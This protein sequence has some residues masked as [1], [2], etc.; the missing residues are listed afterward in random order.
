MHRVSATE[1]IDTLGIAHF[2]GQSTFGALP[3]EVIVDMLENGEIW[4]LA[5]GE[6]IIREDEAARDFQVI[7]QGKIAYY[8]HCEGH[9]VLTRHFAPGEQAG[10]D[11][12]LG[13]IRHN[14][15]DVAVQDTM[16]LSITSVQ[17]H[18]LHRR[19]PSAFG[20]LMINLARELSR[21]I[22]MLEDVITTSTGWMPAE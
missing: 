20:V 22:E 17:F 1:V 13:L 21:E 5:K 15:T 7:L 2:R 6:Y 9:A 18:D 12:M 4:Q 16:M 8:K 10:F 14:G 3:D 19:H 11:L